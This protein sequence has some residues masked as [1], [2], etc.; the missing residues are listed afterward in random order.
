M[1]GLKCMLRYIISQL[2]HLSESK[3]KSFWFSASIPSSSSYV[4]LH[5]YMYKGHSKKGTC[6]GEKSSGFVSSW[7]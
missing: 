7:S 6:I 2:C 5:W 1:F 4:T 3:T